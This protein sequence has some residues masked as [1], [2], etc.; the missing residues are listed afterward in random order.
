[1]SQQIFTNLV[2]SPIWIKRYA[3][4]Q[5]FKLQCPKNRSLDPHNSPPINLLIYL[6]KKKGMNLKPNKCVF[7][8]I[9]TKICK[10]FYCHIGNCNEILDTM[11][12]FKK[13]YLKS[14]AFKRQ[15]HFICHCNQKLTC[16]YNLRPNIPIQH[17]EYKFQNTQISYQV[18]FPDPL[19]G[20]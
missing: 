5:N 12:L 13:N 8:K 3:L 17:K 19:T 15:Q 20:L 9:F 18:N 7:G 4:G 6:A 14:L 11:V 16:G 2:S 1:M 10:H